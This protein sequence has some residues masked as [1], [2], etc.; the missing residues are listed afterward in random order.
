MGRE[1]EGDG[2]RGTG[3]EDVIRKGTREEDEKAR[4]GGGESCQEWEKK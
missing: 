2:G 4:N 1:R 3:G